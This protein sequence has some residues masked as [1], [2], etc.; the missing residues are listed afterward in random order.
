MISARGRARTRRFLLIGLMLSLMVHLTGGSLYG[1]LARAVDRMM[2]HTGS[3][4]SPTVA[5]SDIIRLEKAQPTPAPVAVAKV[6]AKP[7]PPPPPPP[8]THVQPV[9]IV[10]PIQQ[11]HEIAHI[12]VHAP[13]QYAPSR[14]EGQAEIPH[15]VRP[16]AAPKT[17]KQ[18]YYSDSQLAQLNSQFS[19]AIQSA[20]Q[21]VQQANQ[22]M[23]TAPVATVKHF[24]MQFNGIHEGMNPGDGIITVIGEGQRKGDTIWYFTHYEYM[25]GDG[26]VEEDDIPWPFHYPI[27]D[28]PF[29]RHDRRVPLQAPPEGYKPTRPLK[30]ILMQFFGG[31]Q[32][33]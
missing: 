14:G 9:P 2:P 10:A 21:T 19:Q 20:H 5:K 29:A 3:K 1:I 30:P 6:Q 17:P 12:V 16:P 7:K 28:D 31:P 23:D 22:A 33:G 24:Q 26:H 4:Q 27:H 32:V 18:Q 11:H 8:T 25:Y 15:V 13:R